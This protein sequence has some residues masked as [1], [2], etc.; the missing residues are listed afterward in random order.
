MKQNTKR[1]VKPIVTKFAPM[2]AIRNTWENIK[3]PKTEI[4][5]MTRRVLIGI[6]ICAVGMT[7]SL[8]GLR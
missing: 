5:G 7:A 4:G 3:D 8:I 6:G 1:I 2:K